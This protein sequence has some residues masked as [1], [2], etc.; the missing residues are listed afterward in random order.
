MFDVIVVGAGVV[1]P[2]VATSLARQ[3]R[4]VLIVEREWTM[5]N[6]IVGELMQPAGV[7]AL[8]QLGMIRAINNIDAIHVDGY[9][10]SYYGEHVDIKY[11]DKS[12]LNT[13]DTD[14]VPGALKD[15]SEDKLES[16][17]TLDIAEWDNVS[18]LRG[19]AFHHGEFLM[20]LRMICLEEPNVTKLEG[21]VTDLLHEG[22][23]V[24]GVK[25]GNTDEYRAKLVVCCDGIYSKFRKELYHEKQPDIG[26]YF[27]GLDL[28]DA[29]LPRKNHGHVIL[30]KH[31]PILVYQISPHHTRI[32][33]AYRSSQLPKQ[34]EVLE[35]LRSQVLVSLPKSLQP[36]F[37][38]AL[39]AEKNVYK[40]MPNQFLTA[41]PNTV[42]GLICIGDSLNMRHPLTGGGMTVGLND[43]VLLGKLLSTVS[44]DEL[45]DHGIMLEK[46]LTFHGER[47]PLDAVLNT[48]S[49]ALY[50]LFAADSKYM[51]L[52]Q[53]GCFGYFQRGGEC[54]SGPVGLLS[55]MIQRPGLL[56]YHFFNVA[57]YSCYMNFCDRGILLSPLALWENICTL[58]IAACVLLPYLVKEML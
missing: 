49:I 57:F 43:A 26:S 53:R 11:P 39:Q 25:V 50:T 33:C 36:C 37:E 51:E 45:L 30:G 15:G 14:P 31:A 6:R 54:I 20:N 1:G 35:Y 4:K 48:L 12:V 9:Y 21:N 41:K 46:M 34:K 7:K 23:R 17:S 3:G 56:F 55:G 32:L 58:A 44:N 2:C 10:V 42:P 18:T 40:S 29:Q 27:V 24:V 13:I 38:K 5:P 8:K 47:I 28:V 22:E 19:V 52:L 16:D